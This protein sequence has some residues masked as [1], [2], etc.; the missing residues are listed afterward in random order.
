M[1]RN[2]QLR[3]LDA[4]REREASGVPFELEALVEGTGYKLSTLKTYTTKRLRDTLLFE[5][6]E[7][8]LL[9]RGAIEISEEAF[10]RRLGQKRAGHDL[11]DEG[12]AVETLCLRSKEHLLL[13]LT[14][15][16]RPLSNCR[17]EAFCLHMSRAWALLLTASLAQQ[18]MEEVEALARGLL[19][20]P[21]T[22][23]LS[24]A[25]ERED[26]PV[27][28][29]IALVGML[30]RLPPVVP[31]TALIGPLSRLFQACVLNFVGRWRRVSGESIAV[32]GLSGVLCEAPVPD[33][34]ALGALYGLAIAEQLKGVL[35]R[36]AR[37]EAASRSPRF[38]VPRGY[39]W[40]LVPMGEVE[41]EG[42]EAQEE[43]AEI[44]AP[45]PSLFEG[46]PVPE[47]VVEVEVVPEVQPET[48][49]ELLELIFG[50]LKGEDRA[51]LSARVVEGASL[52]RLEEEHGMSAEALRG[53]LGEI[54]DRL[55][56]VCGAAAGGLVA[57]LVQVMAECGG[58]L[59]RD[60]V[61]GLVGVSDLRQVGLALAVAGHQGV[62]RWRDEFLT[63]VP[64][65]EFARRLSQLGDELRG[66]RQARLPMIRVMSMA[67]EIAGLSLPRAAFSRLLAVAFKMQ[68]GEDDRLVLRRTRTDRLLKL[69]ATEARPMHFVEIVDA[70]TARHPGD[71]GAGDEAEA[72][73]G[74]QRQLEASLSAILGAHEDVYTL[75]RDTFVHRV[76]LPI[77]PGRLD[78]IVAWCVEFTEGLTGAI[79]PQRMLGEL[80]RVGKDRRGLGAALLRDALSRHSDIVTFKNE[81]LIAHVES[82]REEGL[83]L[84]QWLERILREHEEPLTLPQVLDL[85]PEGVN[86]HRTAVHASLLT[87]PWAI[88]LGRGR[89]DHIE[90]IG[91]D[92][93]R[94]RSLVDIAVASLPEEGT[95]VACRAL[96]DEINPLE[97]ALGQG[98]RG[99]ALAILWGLLH[100]DERA[101]CGPGGLVARSRDE[102]ARNL[103]QDAIVEVLE[104]LEVAHIRQL[105]LELTARYGHG[106]MESAFRALLRDCVDRGLI[107]RLPGRLYALSPQ[108]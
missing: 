47:A 4:L 20:D 95:P 50:S 66:Q 107:K 33:E 70:Y 11:D 99:K 85:L 97:P 61:D 15:Y 19:G 101:Q 63:S 10:L 13:A 53:R 60:Q 14:L 46:E 56:G 108:R 27:S 83:T 76:A 89:F 74:D 32:D 51:L 41:P 87:A 44:E 73:P 25:F 59:H 65:D 67:N 96:L 52:E 54:V 28:R 88:S 22:H 8:L 71:E 12:R 69:L 91:L 55:R 62:R 43:E 16:H 86:F 102:G 17:A 24:R 79:S 48:L 78:E 64:S 36:L 9:V 6:E 7:G 82:F 68:I 30:S 29:N 106:G 38:A 104:D 18:E 103:L 105:R 93:A 2:R 80:D 39:R 75:G 92:A 31:L 1:K 94:R 45:Q 84:D 21:D 5:D 100:K 26:D 34:D 3:L 37:E 42:E 23:V 98:H 35:A 58:V 72:E 81:H 49:P 40:Q 90:S 57:P 77:P